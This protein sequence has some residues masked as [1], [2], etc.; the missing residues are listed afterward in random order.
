MRPKYKDILETPKKASVQMTIKE[1]K[2]LADILSKHVTV[3]DIEKLIVYLSRLQK[4]DKEAAGIILWGA[5][6]EKTGGF[7]SP[8][9]RAT[10]MHPLRV[11]IICY[12]DD[13]CALL[14]E[15]DG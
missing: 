14:E 13:L 11:F 2:V 12:L 8:I 15:I 6:L 3:K 9:L 10:N 7:R 1:A 4:T 5:I